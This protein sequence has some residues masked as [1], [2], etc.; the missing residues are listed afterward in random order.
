MLVPSGRCRDH[1]RQADQARGTRQQRGYTNA[2]LHY[3]RSRLEQHP[4]CVGYPLGYHSIPTAA[5]VTDHILSAKSRPDQFW[6]PANHQSLCAA[7][8]SRKAVAEEGGFGR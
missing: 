3:S 2:W 1:A 6:N 8:N 7:C 4:L 5:T